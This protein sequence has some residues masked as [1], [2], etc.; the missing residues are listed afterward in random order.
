VVSVGRAAELCQAPSESDR[1][2]P[3][4]VRI[5]GKGASDRMYERRD[6]DRLQPER[7]YHRQNRGADFTK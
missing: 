7:K 4:S 2:G 5:T 3:K 6:P 1:N